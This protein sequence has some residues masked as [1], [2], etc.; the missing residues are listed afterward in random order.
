MLIFQ[1]KN[2]SLGKYAKR[3]ENGKPKNKVWFDVETFQKA[4][5]MIEPDLTEDK[6]NACCFTLSEEDIR[7]LDKEDNGPINNVIAHIARHCYGAKLY[8]DHLGLSVEMFYVNGI[9]QLKGD[10]IQLDLK[11]ADYYQLLLRFCVLL[12]TDYLEVNALNAFNT[13][14]QKLRGF[15]E[16]LGFFTVASH[17]LKQFKGQNVVMMSPASR[18]IIKVDFIDQTEFYRNFFNN[19]FDQKI[20]K[21]KKY[22]YLMVN[23]DTSLIKIGKS[24]NPLYRERTL[25]SQEPSVHLI[26]LWCCNQQVEKKLH[27]KFSNKR[28]RGEWFRLTIP[29]L[30]EIEK[31][32][33]NEISSAQ[34]FE[35]GSH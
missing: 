35:T 5:K 28:V 31:F 15:L 9:R 29:D 12:S 33:N 3:H 30:A 16:K 26:A 22:V 13:F 18:G 23:T 4:P 6:F 34:E 32:M 21:E 8:D 25:H 17:E 11:D 1:S 14:Q 27:V 10:I 20:E 24:N 2:L 19:I 7:K